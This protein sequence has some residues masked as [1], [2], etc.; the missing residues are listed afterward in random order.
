MKISNSTYD[1]G[2]DGVRSHSWLEREAIVISDV[3]VVSDEVVI[4]PPNREGRRLT[5]WTT[6][7]EKNTV[8][9][10]GKKSS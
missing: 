2:V 5:L 6:D 3:I 4:P 8:V 9:R 7:H 10:D 1:L